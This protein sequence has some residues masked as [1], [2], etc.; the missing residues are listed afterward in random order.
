MTSQLWITG[1]LSPSLSN[2][3][4]CTPLGRG[5]QTQMTTSP[6]CQL[7]L[8]RAADATAVTHLDAKDRLC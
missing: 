7:P 3:I 6:S 5:P 4:I 1:V 2:G 8:R